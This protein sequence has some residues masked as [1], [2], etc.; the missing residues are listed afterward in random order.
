M[1]IAQALANTFS[2][3]NLMAMAPANRV[4]IYQTIQ[5]DLL[6][7]YAASGANQ[8]AVSVTYWQNT[9]TI[10][11]NDARRNQIDN[12]MQA[13]TVAPK[14]G[15]GAKEHLFVIGVAGRN[16]AGNPTKVTIRPAMVTDLD[17]TSA[18]NYVV[19]SPVAAGQAQ[20]I[21]AAGQGLQLVATPLHAAVGPVAD[22]LRAKWLLMRVLRLS[23]T[24][25]MAGCPAARS[26]YRFD[27]ATNQLVPAFSGVN[28]NSVMFTTAAVLN[29]IR[30]RPFR[31]KAN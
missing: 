7:L 15:A 22:L 26:L 29:A 14:P 31:P 24:D 10:N 21:Q 16:S 20:T 28:P 19:Y 25:H 4:A 30:F 23:D 13:E 5:R 17:A 18:S 12:E 1:S 3:K 2:S 9:F 11:L 8:V 27:S 6:A